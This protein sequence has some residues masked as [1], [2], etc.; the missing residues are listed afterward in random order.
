MNGF[1]ANFGSKSWSK[2]ATTFFWYYGPY[3]SGVIAEK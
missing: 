3:R 2:K 1:P